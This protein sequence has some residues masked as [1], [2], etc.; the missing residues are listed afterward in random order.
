MKVEWI[1]YLYDLKKMKSSVQRCIK[2]CLL[3]C[4]P[5]TAKKN[6]GGVNYYQQFRKYFIKPDGLAHSEE[7]FKDTT[8]VNRLKSFTCEFTMRPH[9]GLSEFSETAIENAKYVRENL[10]IFN[11]EVIQR[12]LNKADDIVQSL[13]LFNQKDKSTT[14]KIISSH[15]I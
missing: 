9:V 8:L 15:C 12:F 14:G 2:K 1:Q 13:Q 11:I 5:D 4:F 10:E 7:S 3:Y 6:Q